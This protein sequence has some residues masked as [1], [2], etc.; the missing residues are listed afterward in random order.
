MTLTAPVENGWQLLNAE[1]MGA[2]YRPKIKLNI[3]CYLSML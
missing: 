1:C 2:V 3:E